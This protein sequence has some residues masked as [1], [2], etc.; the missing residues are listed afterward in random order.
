MEALSK[1]HAALSRQL[2]TRRLKSHASQPAAH[3]A[4]LGPGNKRKHDDPIEFLS[5]LF[6]VDPKTDQPNG[7]IPG[8][9]RQSERTW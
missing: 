4:S 9:R 1:A 7:E 6:Q 5:R 8:I 3:A 2:V